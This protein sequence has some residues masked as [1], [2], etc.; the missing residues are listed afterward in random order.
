MHNERGGGEGEERR[1]NKFPGTALRVTRSQPS[2]C[3][4]SY[5]RSRGR[6]GGGGRFIQITYGPEWTSKVSG[7]HF[8]FS[9]T[10]SQFLL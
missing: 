7:I 10:V 2:R 4:I 5:R 8:P 3:G 1:E 6:E 9:S